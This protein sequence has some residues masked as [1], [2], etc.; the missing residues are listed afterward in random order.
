[1]VSSTR[2]HFLG[3]TANYLGF[4]DILCMVQE[5]VSS[6]R[7]TLSFADLYHDLQAGCD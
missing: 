6:F 5:I 1:M 3:S 7:I 2:V 4:F